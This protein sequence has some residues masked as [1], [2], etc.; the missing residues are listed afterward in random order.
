VKTG[1]GGVKTVGVGLINGGTHPPNKQDNTKK[2]QKRL[3]LFIEQP[4][5]HRLK[6]SATAKYSQIIIKSASFSPILY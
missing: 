2:N 6:Y 5:L 1:G 4:Q 3:H